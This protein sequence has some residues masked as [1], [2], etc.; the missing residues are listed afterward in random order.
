MGKQFQQCAIQLRYEKGKEKEG[1]KKIEVEKEREKRKK[2]KKKERELIFNNKINSKSTRRNK[3]IDVWECIQGK[4]RGWSTK[5]MIL[6]K[7]SQHF[8]ELSTSHNKREDTV[9]WRLDGKKGDRKS[10]VDNKAKK[11]VKCLQRQQ[12]YSQQGKEVCIKKS[13]KIKKNS[14]KDEL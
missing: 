11:S 5:E 9:N 7:N 4:H 1:K 6:T 14:S 10:D 12:A 13:K 2:V 8:C 3:E